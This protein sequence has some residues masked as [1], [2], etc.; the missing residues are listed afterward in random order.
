M[1]IGVGK[2]IFL[3]TNV[4]VFSTATRAPFHYAARQAI[5]ELHDA[6]AE[7]WVSRQVLREYLAT[8]SRSQTFSI[9]QPPDVLAADVRS[10]SGPIRHGRR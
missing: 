9:P 1:T 6:G 4:L 7:L 2:K 5:Q 3:D 8:L 10:L